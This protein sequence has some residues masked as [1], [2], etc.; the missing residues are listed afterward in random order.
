MI[1][2]EFLSNVLTWYHSSSFAFLPFWMRLL[3]V[4]M[5][6][7]SK[8]KLTPSTRNKWI[9]CFL[10]IAYSLC[11]VRP[12]TLSSF[13]I[14]HNCLH[15]CHE[16][17]YN[18]VYVTLSNMLSLIQSIYLLTW[19]Y[20]W[21]IIVAMII[22]HVDKMVYYVLLKIQVYS[23]KRVPENVLTNGLKSHIFVSLLFAMLYQGRLL[24]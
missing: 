22:L 12:Y 24:I 9:S 20:W 1:I 2:K 11:F 23:L 14:L 18:T 15:K 3:L 19:I 5:W 13:A 6:D 16:Y 21:G 10:Y 4:I 8:T 17:G 7:D